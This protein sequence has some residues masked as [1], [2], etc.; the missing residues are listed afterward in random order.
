M[1]VINTKDI[2]NY[3]SIRAE[4]TSGNPVFLHHTGFMFGIGCDARDQ[5]AIQKINRIKQ[6]IPEKGYIMLIP[7][8]DWLDRMGISLSAKHIRLLDQYSPGNLTFV[9]PYS[10][11]EY[12]HLTTDGTLALRIPAAINLRDFL[13]K[14]D[15][16]MVSTSINTAGEEPLNHL[17]TI[18]RRFGVDIPYYIEE[19]RKWEPIPSTIVRLQDDFTVLRAG[20]IPQA[21]LVQSLEKPL[22]TFICTGNICRSPIAEYLLKDRIEKER[23][24]L[25]SESAGFLTSGN[26]I[27]K[28][29]QTLLADAGIDASMHL[30]TQINHEI[31]RKSWLLVTMTQE[32][33]DRLLS[34]IPY[35]ENKVKL[36]SEFGGNGSDIEDPY[37]GSLS[38]YRYAYM[39]IETHIQTLIEYYKNTQ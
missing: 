24:E 2:A 33:K 1:K 12:R 14:L 10:G 19:K 27:S 18:Y 38:D 13:R 6:R 26:S 22:V 8:L 16:P 25:R 28:H 5:R 35:V 29:S 4:V 39:R 21:E 36:L 11:D 31:I 3:E 37:G 7:G 23:L 15:A 20:N 32:H 17:D 9:V 34:I 30:S